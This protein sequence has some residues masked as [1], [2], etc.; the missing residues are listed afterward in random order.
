MNIL[1]SRS[2][3]KSATNY[4][5]VRFPDNGL[6]IFF[7]NISGHYSFLLS[8]LIIF[9]LFAVSTQSTAQKAVVYGTITDD[10]SGDPLT[11]VN[12]FFSEKKKVIS[13]AHGNYVIQL[14]KPQN[15]NLHFKSIGYQ[16]MV[17]RISVCDS[18]R[19]DIRLQSVDY[20]LQGVTVTTRSE[21]RKLKESGMPVSVIG[22]QQLQGTASN[23][24][25]VLARTVGVTVRNTGGIGSASRIS[26]RGL[27]GKRMGMFIDETPLGQIGNFVALNDI[28]TNMIERIEV[29][30]G[31]VP[32]KFGGSALGG[33][34]NVVLKEYP[35]VYLDASYE[36]SSFNTHQI[37]T[38]FKCTDRKS[39]LQFGIGGFYTYAGNN[40]KMQLSNLDD[41]IV[42][43]DHDRFR[44]LTGG[45]SVKATRWWF[46]KVKLELVLMKTKQEVQGIDMNVKEAYNDSYSFVSA[47]NLK[48]KN[49]FL[50]GLDFDF[51][52][53]FVYGKYGLHDQAM[54]RYDWDGNRLPPV[55]S[56]GGEQ[57][58][59][60]SDGNN[61][62]KD[63]VGK[64]NLA[65]TIDLHH[66]VNLNIYANRTALHP[67][68]LL[69]NKALGF[70]ANYPS[71]M[72]N[73]T[74]GLSYDL[75]L[76]NGKFQ[77]AFTLKDFSFSSHSRS[78]DLFAINEPEPV[79]V[80]K[81][82]FGFSNALRY[83]L[84]KELMVKASFNSEVRIPTNEE[85]IGNGYSILPSPALKPER[86]SGFNLG[87]LYRKLK[88]HGGIVECEVGLFYNRLEDMIR[89][90]PDMIPTMARYRNF[91]SVRTMGVEVEAKVDV[92]PIL[93]LYANTTYQD[94]RDVRSKIPG[95]D[96]DNPTKEMRIP[97]VPYLL[98]NFGAEFH[99]ENLFG[100]R[101]QNTRI[102]FDASYI[103]QYFYDFEMSKYQ[104]RKIPT[105]LNM[106]AAI[107]HSFCNDQWVL[108][109]KVKNVGN[110][111][112]LS[113]LNRPLPGR[114]V[115]FKLR[116]LF[117]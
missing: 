25:D 16:P 97:N 95:T 29:Y 27:E 43:R 12:V 40:Y 59:H 15:V 7:M 88:R 65:Y 90:T 23:I 87:T 24:N 5:E 79:K 30:K 108:T 71:T 58:N 70:N 106:D 41:R 9:F 83:T 39:G 46:D 4:N 86:T 38:I 28:P 56:Y 81:N 57:G 1:L 102:L 63:L 93:Y 94:L 111:R 101:Q 60:P 77:N 89:F 35:P 112:I 14:P 78:I 72:N 76:F 55:S 22:Q 66:S 31:I 45:F 6:R 47:I 18:I 36:I 91:G 48:R 61:R 74:V 92:C 82:Y 98:A 42:E 68:D 26:V 32:Y 109:F 54:C 44:K 8:W 51:D 105:S 104:E 11:G 69:M 117:K 103:H 115:A 20:E 75:S 37:S 13:D 52:F 19:V 80:A 100:G 67:E 33:A 113:E 99:K 116:Y 34:V 96:V 2:R 64:L 110:R 62:S 107:E 3:V 49:F 114:S 50:D 73:V 53:G 10:I 85:L 21:I 17:K 84:T